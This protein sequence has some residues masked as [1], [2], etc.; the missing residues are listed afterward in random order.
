M[1]VELSGGSDYCISV[2]NVPFPSSGRH[3]AVVEM[4]SVE[5]EQCGVR[6][7]T[8]AQPHS[9]RRSLRRLVVLGPEPEIP[10]VPGAKLCAVLCGC[11]RN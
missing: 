4:T 9:A 1:K 7:R 10:G 8:N 2:L 11:L 3:T 6:G 5:D